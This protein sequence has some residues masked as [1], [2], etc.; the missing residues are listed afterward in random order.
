MV[1]FLGL[2]F[3][4]KNNCFKPYMKENAKLKYVSHGSNHPA[5]VLENIPYNINKRL[6]TISSSKECFKK[7]ICLY[8]KAISDAG[9]KYELK[10]EKV[11]QKRPKQYCGRSNENNVQFNQVKKNQVVWFNPPF[12][13]YCGTN[14]GMIFRDLIQKHFSGGDDLSKL[15]NKNRL[16]ISYSCLPNIACKISAHN[17]FLLSGKAKITTSEKICNCQKSRICPLKGNCVVENSVYRAQ[18]LKEGQTE[19]EGNMYVGLHTGLFKLRLANHE[20]SF[21]VRSKAKC[22]LGKYICKL[23]DRGIEHFKTG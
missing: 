18:V 2:V 9:Y 7:D 3:D 19:K 11:F 5:I 4:L 1:C 15:F 8:Q 22:E 12:N 21:K 13:L 16:K 23:K 14:V 10:Y 6:S 17:K 20:Q